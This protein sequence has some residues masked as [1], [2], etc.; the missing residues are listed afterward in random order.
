MAKLVLDLARPYR[1]WLAVILGA[2]LLET[3]AGLAAPWPLKVVIDSAIGH[4]TP[5]GWLAGLLG[6]AA[7]SDPR[8]LT[9]AAAAAM[10]LIAI[11][12]GVASYV[13]S[14][15]TESVGQWVAND[16][17]LRIYEHLESLS[18]RYF[19]THE[20]GALLS[21]MTDDVARVQ[22]FV[23]SDA[24]GMLVDSMTIAGML[25]VML[26]LD[27][28][29][30]LLVVVS[31]PVLLLFIS[32]FRRAVKQ[33][34]REV[35]L[36]ES[37]VVTIVQTGLESVRTV[38][39]LG[40]QAV[41][42]ARLAKASHA[43]VAAALRARR[44]KSLLPP[45]IGVIVSACTAI[46]LWRGTDLVLSGAMTVGSLT[47]FLA[48]LARF[49]KPVQD[50]GKMT[51]AVAQTHVA[52]E[53]IVSLLDIDM[54]VQE[55]SDAVEPPPLTGA[56]EFDHVAF[57]YLPD[58]QVLRDVTLS[59]P[60]GSFVGVVGPT[61]SGKSTI[62][63]L[64]PRFYDA[65]A[66]RILIDRT[67]VRGYT[68]RGLR[69]QIG[70]VLQETVLFRGTIRD[71]IAYGRQDATDGEIATAARLANAEEFIARLPDGYTTI[72]GERGATLS[73]G[74]RQRIG[75]ARAFIRDTP[76]LILD[77]P[78]AS[79]DAESELLVMQG[80]KRLMQ[81]RTV[82]MISHRLDTLRDAHT[83]VVLHGG[84]VAEQ[85]TH[86]GLLAR[87]GLYAG[88]YWAATEFSTSRP[89][90][91]AARTIADLELPWPDR[92]SF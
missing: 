20:T 83:I 8:A 11:L 19:D 23:S 59:I 70:I 22:D 29:F 21:T 38:Q 32:R 47:V 42:E 64:I 12:A 45:F 7:A 28:N 43:T 91:A 88:L 74:Q 34:T 73:G 18:L 86:D 16:L 72:V 53:R 41:E 76:I 4:R 69:R 82:I 89:T 87:N 62:A 9:V 6:A 25:A 56:I 46:V 65:T 60:A 2:M 27:W 71:N 48:Y 67:D 40:A 17:R 68:L 24:L 26:W 35:R 81:G 10:V 15:Y 55:R 44:I 36:R 51:N 78:T 57:A 33:A 52:L 49:F 1:A 30:A 13:D 5:P 92:S 54:T 77:E 37:D 63:S 3:L 79:L 84:V 85:G 14:Y 50:L 80:L 90:V 58:A 31:T 39:A 75:I 61:G 66:G